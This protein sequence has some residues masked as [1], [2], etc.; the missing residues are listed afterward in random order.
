[1]KRCLSLVAVLGLTLVS[2]ALAASTNIAALFASQVEAVKGDARAPAVL[3]PGAMPVGF[4]GP[5][6]PAHPRLY[7]EGGP[8]GSSY[9]LYLG[10]LPRC[11]GT[12]SCSVATFSAKQGAKIL[13]GFTTVTVP[14]ATQA[15][16]HGLL[17]GGSCSPPEIEYIVHGVLYTIQAN[18]DVAQAQD[19]ATM[20]AAAE[21]SIKAGPR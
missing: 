11:D 6:A 9:V 1:M 10:A 17:C 18:L 5:H 12:E 14:G 16:Y 2:T 3:L 19:Q 8:L 13:P 15:Q 21:S 4:S 20:I 7:A